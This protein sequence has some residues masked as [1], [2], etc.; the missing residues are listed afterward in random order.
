MEIKLQVSVIHVHVHMQYHIQKEGEEGERERWCSLYY[1]GSVYNVHTGLRGVN[2]K[3]F[4]LHVHVHS[5]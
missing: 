1:A 5:T 2:I 4:E 3:R